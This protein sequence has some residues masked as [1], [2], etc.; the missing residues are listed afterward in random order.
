MTMDLSKQDTLVSVIVVTYNSSA[1]VIET[2][3]SIRQQT[4]EN[5]ELVISDDC[6]KDD[7][8]VVCS[9]WLDKNKDRFVGVEL[10]TIGHNTG[11]CANFNRAIAVAKGEWIKIIAGDDILLQNC[12]N[13][14]IAF[15]CANPEAKWASSYIRKYNNNFQE[16]NCIARRHS[17]VPSF[18][19]LDISGQLKL[20]ARQCVL[21]APSLFINAAMLKS[22]GGFDESYVAED[23]PFYINAL[24]N[25]YKCYFL[26]KETVGY[27][28]HTSLCRGQNV[29]FNAFFK[30]QMRRFKKEKCFKYLSAWEKYGVKLLWITDDTFEKLHLNRNRRFLA[31]LY[32]FSQSLV[33]HVF[34]VSY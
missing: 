5:I 25:G 11:V 12:I 27:R 6:S 2:L 13:D 29:L 9:E 16:K 19:D 34:G 17:M 21:Y 22:I 33:Y 20:M 30:N 14:Y 3:D 23:Y 26:N 8:V 4:Y 10:L 1:T 7:T 31:H 28:I 24:E 18:F 15:I 32:F